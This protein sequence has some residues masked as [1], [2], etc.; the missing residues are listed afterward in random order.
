M[1]RNAFTT[2]QQLAL[3]RLNTI[4]TELKTQ[5]IQ[6]DDEID[7]LCIS[8]L[9]E[10]NM[11]M[12]GPPGTAK[13]LLTRVFANSLAV[14]KEQYFERLCHAYTVPEELFGPF[15]LKKLEEG[16][17]E[18]KIERYLPTAR[19]AYL[20]EIFNMNKTQLNTM[21][22][23]LNE[24]E[25]DNGAGRID[26]PLELCVGT[27]N[28]YPEG[29]M[30]LAALYDRFLVRFWTPYINTRGGRRKLLT[31]ANEPSCTSTL[32]DGDTELLRSAVKS[33]TVPEDV[34]EAI[35]DI[36]DALAKKGIVCSDRRW[37]SMMKLVRTMAALNLRSTATLR[38]C[39]ILCD[40]L[41]DRH[42]QRPEIYSVVSER[43]APSIGEAQRLL[44]GAVS[45]FSA[46]N[47][48]D[49]D[50]RG[51]TNLKRQR[52]RVVGI[53]NQTLR[54]ISHVQ[55]AADEPEIQDMMVKVAGMKKTLGRA[56]ARLDLRIGGLLN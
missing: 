52:D 54:E 38:D 43:C 10:T 15:D 37:R 47:L 13:S 6:R 39:L 41:W 40:S 27:A 25:F 44:D 48:A 55:G 17:Y 21:N 45:E 22:T 31:A 56:I 20:D 53:L 14:P 29:D 51:E 28:V 11:L 16:E 12:L 1:A 32:L 23:V 50:S 24:N 49:R 46:V 42:E 9:A 26:C 36:W 4:R 34:V 8:L 3:N 5:F 2:G 19:V 33:V 18:R 30:A 7:G 35:M